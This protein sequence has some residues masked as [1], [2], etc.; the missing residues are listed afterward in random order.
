MCSA[1]PRVTVIVPAY[2]YAHFLPCAL[3]S[4]LRQ[5]FTDWECIV[6]DDGSTDSTPDVVGR[7]VDRDQRF[8]CL[9][10]ENR[11]PA[12]ARNVGIASS[13][14]E[15]IQFLDA[16]DRLSPRKLEKHVRF[17]DEHPETDIVYG[18]V[19]FFRSDDP[20][21]VFLSL[22]GKL[23]RSIMA[24]VH[25]NAEAL[26]KLEHYNIM[27]MLAAVMR[28]RVFE[29]AGM[30]DEAAEGCEDYGLWI[31][32]AVAGCRF[33]YL[34]TE[35]GV[36]SVRSHGSST[37]RDAERMIR[38][39]IEIAK[40]FR[41]SAAAATL[42]QNRLPLIYE[43]ALGIDCTEHSSRWRGFRRIWRAAGAATESLTALRWR[44]YALAGLL[45]TR[46]AFIRLVSYPMP[47]LGLEMYRRAR[48]LLRRTS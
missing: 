17:L 18:E 43:V 47:E 36:A 38:G 29:R 31:R 32:C 14:G 26:Q 12:A 6:V 39:L 30:F 8:R 11:G 41:N 1:R 23:S 45:L 21:K 4:V 2:N 27:P 28:R 22:N 13:H 48:A 40:A 16:D 15:M 7:F 33:D 24:H 19:T 5:T 3:D 35:G 10:Q 20:E 42:R 46:P 34:E 44:V 25:G 9:R 37:S